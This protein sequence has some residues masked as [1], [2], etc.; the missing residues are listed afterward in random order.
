MLNKATCIFVG[1][2]SVTTTK[3]TLDALEYYVIHW[4][5]AGITIPWIDGLTA[6]EC[7]IRWAQAQE[8]VACPC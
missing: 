8:N 4:A 2:D 5:D 6:K 7:V 1:D 3:P